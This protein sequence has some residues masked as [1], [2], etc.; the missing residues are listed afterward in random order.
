MIPLPDISLPAYAA[1]FFGAFCL[2]VA[3][4]GL[5]GLA[6]INVIIMAELFRKESVGIVL[7]LLILADLVVYPIYRRHATWR[8]TWPLL[9]PATAGVCL[10]YFVLRA[11]DDHTTKTVIGWTILGMLA[12]Q[13]LRMRSPELLLHLPHSRRFLAVSGLVIGISTTVA[14]AAGPVYS[15]WGLLKG[16]PKNLFLGMGARVF[17]FLNLVKLP[18]NANLG[19]V[20][21]RTLLL[22]AT[23]VPAVLLGIFVG[24]PF[25]QRLPEAVFQRVLFVLSAIGAFWLIAT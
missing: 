3:K 13:W 16:L 6:L 12:L 25:V 18:F 21:G 2:G 23:L 5:P 4:T 1:A 20:N 19:I 15:I 9:V 11:I 14:N 7:P 8:D 22:D 10:G 24:R 17:L